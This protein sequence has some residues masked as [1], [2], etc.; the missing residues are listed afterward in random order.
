MLVLAGGYN[1]NNGQSSYG[2]G[3]PQTGEIISDKISDKFRQ[4]I[5]P[6]YSQYLVTCDGQTELL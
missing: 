1:V 5:R 4:V 6:F 3:I 2:P